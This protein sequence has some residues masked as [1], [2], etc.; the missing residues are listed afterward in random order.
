M[1]GEE[2]IKGKVTSFVAIDSM[3]DGYYKIVGVD[4]KT[5]EV[6]ESLYG[7]RDLEEKFNFFLDQ[8]L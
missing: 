4:V 7:R 6:K 8:I 5:V 3:H 2:K 1:T